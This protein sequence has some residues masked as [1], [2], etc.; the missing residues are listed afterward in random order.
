MKICHLKL[1]KHLRDVMLYARGQRASDNDNNN[2]TVA[3]VKISSVPDLL[4]SSICYLKPPFN[5]SP[6]A[7]FVSLALRPP[8]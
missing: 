4:T 7:E 8:I 3:C 1:F 6:R 2:T 5:Q